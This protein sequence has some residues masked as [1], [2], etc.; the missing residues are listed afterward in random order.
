MSSKTTNKQA[1]L[2]FQQTL[3]FFPK[4]QPNNQMYGQYKE[5]LGRFA[6]THAQKL[7]DGKLQKRRERKILP[8]KYQRKLNGYI[9][10]C[11]TNT[12]V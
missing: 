12:P 5:D 3:I 9:I 11:V 6:R 10:T 1:A 7:I 4:N 2:D 8:E